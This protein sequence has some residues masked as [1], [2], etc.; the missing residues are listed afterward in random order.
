MLLETQL[1]SSLMLIVL[2]IESSSKK[3]GW[4]LSPTPLKNMTSSVGMMTFPY[5]MEKKQ[6]FQTTNQYLLLI[7]VKYNLNLHESLILTVIGCFFQGSQPPN[8]AESSRIQQSSHTEVQDAKYLMREQFTFSF[9]AIHV[10]NHLS[11]FAGGFAGWTYVTGFQDTTRGRSGWKR[12]PFKTQ[13]KAIY[14]PKNLNHQ[15]DIQKH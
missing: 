3:S 12:K 4:L 13:K 9:F 6:T 8:G 10:T 1:L 5:I 7:A 11:E 14:H 15:F 2:V